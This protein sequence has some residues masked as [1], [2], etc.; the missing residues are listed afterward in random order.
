M[1]AP[2]ESVTDARSSHRRVPDFFVVGHG[3]SGTTALYE[4]LRR[5]PQI[6][7]PEI[8]ELRFFAADM[9]AHFQHERTEPQTLDAHLSLFDSA[10]PG[11]RVG[12]TSTLYLWSRTAAS[13]IAEVQPAARIIALLREPA[14]Y[15]RSLHLQ[16]LQNRIETQRSLRKA[17]ALEQ[18]RREGR[19]IP[20]GCVRP[21]ALQYSE[22]V[23]YVEQLRRYQA[24]FAREQVLVLIYDDFRRDN[25]AAMRSVLRFLEVDDTHPVEPVEANPTV[26]VRSARLDGVTRSLRTGRGPLARA[27]RDA[28]K[29]LTSQRVRSALYHPAVRR[30]TYGKPPPPDEE[31]MLELRK[32]FRP[33]VEALSSYLDRDLV[34]LW[35][36]DEL[37]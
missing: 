33:E 29:A 21:Q 28:G 27:V 2:A 25:E 12:E 11:E 16:L 32:R 8:K 37:D 6:Y 3:K 22:R 4:M 5:H 10:K 17:I 20:R 14:S 9:D 35:G 19:A 13:A 7:L 15:L 30:A 23:Q 26:A 36:Y 18:A 1:G 34:R 31:L 24:V